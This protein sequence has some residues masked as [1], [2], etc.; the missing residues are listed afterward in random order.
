L[1]RIANI[2]DLWDLQTERLVIDVRTP[3]EFEKGHIPGARQIERCLCTAGEVES[4]A[5]VWDGYLELLVSM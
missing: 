1:S 5:L 2:E 3:A 4:E